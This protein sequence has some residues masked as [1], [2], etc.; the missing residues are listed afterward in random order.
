MVARQWLANIFDYVDCHFHINSR[1]CFSFGEIQLTGFST[2][3]THV[4][5]YPP[6]FLAV[7]WIE[8]KSLSSL[9]ETSTL[10]LSYIYSW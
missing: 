1:K 6:S 7:L 2:H 3:T 5:S 8:L 10:P 4:I 9:G